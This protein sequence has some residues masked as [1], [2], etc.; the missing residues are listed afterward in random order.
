[1][2]DVKS[3]DLIPYAAVAVGN[4]P[5]KALTNQTAVNVTS[6]VPQSGIVDLGACRNN[7]TMQVNANVAASGITGGVATLFYSL[8]G[9]N[10]KTS[11]S[12]VTMTSNTSGFVTLANTPARFIAAGVTTIISGGTTPAVDVFLGSC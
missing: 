5:V 7:H 8:D 11:S 10:W 4:V 1:M 2:A 6:G 12:T 9:V 3:S